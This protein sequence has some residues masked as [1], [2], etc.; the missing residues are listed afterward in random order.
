MDEDIVCKRYQIFLHTW[1][2]ID[3]DIVYRQGYCVSVKDD[4]FCVGVFFLSQTPLWDVTQCQQQL[5]Q[6]LYQTMRLKASWY[7]SKDAFLYLSKWITARSASV[8]YR[9]GMLYSVD[10]VEIYPF[11]CRRTVYDFLLLLVL[12]FTDISC[13]L[14]GVLQN[15]VTFYLYSH[16]SAQRLE[17]ILFY[18]LY[19]RCWNHYNTQYIPSWA[20]AVV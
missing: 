14:C 8:Q 1:W 12:L 7:I 18:C 4:I 10:A 20:P 3:E 9:N 2:C 6:T 16:P 19:G 13:Y 11:M 17:A 15:K 5:V